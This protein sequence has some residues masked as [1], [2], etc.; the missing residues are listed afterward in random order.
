[1]GESGLNGL[2]VKRKGGMKLPS[3]LECTPRQQLDNKYSFVIM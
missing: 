2:D 3:S 1:M